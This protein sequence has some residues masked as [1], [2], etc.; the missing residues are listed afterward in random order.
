MHELETCLN[1]LNQWLA[2]HGLIIEIS[3]I[4]RF[5]FYLSG[6]HQVAT[7]DIDSVTEIE[8]RVYQKILEIGKHRGMK[9]DWLNDNAETLPLPDGFKAR[10]IESDQFSNIKM[11]YAA[12][13]DLI[14]LK[15]AAYIS[16]G[17]DDPKD[18]QD[19]ILLQPTNA[20]IESSIDYIRKHYSSPAERFSADFEE[21]LNELRNHFK[22]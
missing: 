20:E 22:K 15:A 12:R 1:D 4:G 19:L 11:K 21:R 16:R 9:P 7:L 6:F 3:V 10:L 8:E 14:S 13:I 2:E 18:F 5:A 17:E